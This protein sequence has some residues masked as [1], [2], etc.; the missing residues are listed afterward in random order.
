[1]ASGS[2]AAGDEFSLAGVGGPAPAV[3]IV[4]EANAP[5]VDPGYTQLNPSYDQ[6]ENVRP[7]W[8]LAKPLPRVLRPGMIPT[9][10]EF[11]YNQNQTDLEQGNSGEVDATLN[12]GRIATQ[13]EETRRRRENSLMQAISPGG[14]GLGRQSSTASHL[15]PFPNVDE[16]ENDLLGMG[17]VSSFRPNDD[18]GAIPE[19]VEGQE[20]TDGSWG[21]ELTLDQDWAADEEI[22]NLHTHWSVVRLQFREP[23]AELLAVS[24]LLILTCLR[25]TGKGCG[26]INNRLLRGPRHHP[27]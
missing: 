3:Q 14:N 1:M 20:E 26:S 17:R 25:L 11:N 2:I 12:I 4:Q 24:P 6:P 21:E 9:R 16:D 27:R 8:G 5:Y 19:K 13:L 7:V 22:H 10:S 15:S 23:F 18:M